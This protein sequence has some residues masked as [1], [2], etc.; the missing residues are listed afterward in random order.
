MFFNR[1]ELCDAVSLLV[2]ILD[3]VEWFKPVELHTPSGRRGHIKMAIG[4][5]QRGALLELFFRYSWPYE[6]SF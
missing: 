3:D 1:G 5:L 6:M 4:S 2:Y